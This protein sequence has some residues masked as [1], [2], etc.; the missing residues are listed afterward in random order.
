M[1]TDP[2]FDWRDPLRLDDLLSDEERLI[3]DSAHDFAQAEL[4]PLILDWHRHEHFDPAIFPKLGEMGF[5]GMQLEGYGCA[6][7]SYTAYGL[8]ARELER[9]DAAFRSAIGV[10]GGLVMTPIHVFGSDAQKDRYLPVLARGEMIGCF[11]LTEPD[12]GSDPS[13]M[14]A[15]AKSVP[16]GYS[17]SGNKIWITN[18]PIADLFVIWARDD[19]GHVGG[20]L[21]ERGMAG[22]ITAKIEGKFSVR[23]SPTGEV[24]MSDVFVPS[25]SRLPGAKGLK[26]PLYCLNRARLAIAW[27]ALGAAEFCWQATRDYVMAREQFGRPLAANQLIQAKLAEMQTEIT[28]SL[29]ATLRL[30]RLQDAGLATPEMISLVKRA[31]ARRALDVTRMAREMHGGNGISDTYHVVRHMMNLEVENTLEGTADI[32]ALVLGAAQTGIRAF[33]A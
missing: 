29:L 7:A 23:A 24:S 20:F 16:G 17:L 3:R 26:A 10:Q 33:S 31:S 6:G 9:V 21:L 2:H 12:A 27:G 4:M 22:L 32:H 11:G 1:T 13:R 8:V 19:D 18:A 25:E 15:R 30:S 5:L 28:L 14:R